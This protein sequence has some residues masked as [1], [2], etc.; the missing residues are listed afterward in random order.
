MS[1]SK[2]NSQPRQ[3]N[4]FPSQATLPS[5]PLLS[6]PQLSSKYPS[7]LPAKPEGDVSRHSW[8]QCMFDDLIL[9]LEDFS[10]SSPSSSTHRCRRLILARVTATLQETFSDVIRHSVASSVGV[11]EMSSFDFDTFNKAAWNS[12]WE[13]K[14]FTRLWEQRENLELLRYRLRQNIRTIRKI[15]S[16]PLPLLSQNPHGKASTAQPFSKFLEQEQQDLSEWEELENM[17]EY[18]N[19]VIVRTTD[20]YLQTVAARE[21]Q[22]SNFQARR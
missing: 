2:R 21:A 15:N 16:S 19:E 17:V 9:D 4:V 5:L 11:D 1:M 14:K 10:T 6:L 3:V 8:G 13:G 18:I 20:N 7:N 22:V 12:A